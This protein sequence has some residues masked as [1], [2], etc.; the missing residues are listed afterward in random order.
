MVLVETTGLLA[1]AAGGAHSNGTAS[2]SS[3]SPSAYTVPGPEGSHETMR[4]RPSLPGRRGSRSAGRLGCRPARGVPGDWAVC[5]PR[6]AGGCLTRA[7]GRA[8]ASGDFA[9][10]SYWPL[11]VTV[12]PGRLSGGVA[13]SPAPD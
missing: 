1:A 6:A 2:G 3:P 7:G 5:T 9:T 12:R 10:G 8:G 13:G 11:T 4:P